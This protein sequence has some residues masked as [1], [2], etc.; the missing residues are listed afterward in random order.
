[1]KKELRNQIIKAFQNT[2][3]PGDTDIVYDNSDENLESAEIRKNFQQ[4]EWQNVSHD[5]LL[6]NRWSHGFF[7]DNGYRY[8]LPAYMLFVLDDL[9]KSDVIPANLVVSLTASTSEL[10]EAEFKARMDGFTLDQKKAI[11]SFLEYLK[12]TNVTYS[13][14]PPR[15]AIRQY[16]SKY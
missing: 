8:Y 9:K 10:S 11:R 6:Y 3:Y 7:T 16:W 2:K 12:D 14:N 5:I 4:L 15:K 1:M 13:K